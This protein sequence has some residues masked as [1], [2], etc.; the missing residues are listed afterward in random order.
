MSDEPLPTRT[1]G[2]G[3]PSRTDTRVDPDRTDAADRGGGTDPDR[4]RA[5]IPDDDTPPDGAE[6]DG[7]PD[8]DTDEAEPLEYRLERLRLWRILVTLAVV[9]ARLLRS[10]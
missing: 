9:V 3:G 8:G 1:D 7:E 6:A 2:H 4:G 5:P 10:L